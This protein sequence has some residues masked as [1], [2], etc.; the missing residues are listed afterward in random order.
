MPEKQR[1]DARDVLWA[2]Q[3]LQ[4]RGTRYLIDELDESEPDLT[5]YLTEAL[6]LIDR[7]ILGLGG[8]ARASRRTYRRVEELTLVCILAM[9]RRQD[10]PADD[11]DEEASDVDD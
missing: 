11:A 4:R 2:L 1:V 5:D 9:R 10:Q 7:D 8:P 6:S 3:E